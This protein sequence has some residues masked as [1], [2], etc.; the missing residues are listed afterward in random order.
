MIG[1]KVRKLEQSPENG[2]H[3]DAPSDGDGNR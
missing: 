3:H 1:S 2:Q